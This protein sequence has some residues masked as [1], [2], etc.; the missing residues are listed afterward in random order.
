M[1]SRQYSESLSSVDGAESSWLDVLP[2]KKLFSIFRERSSGDTAEGGNVMCMIRENLFVW[3]DHYS[4]SPQILT[5]N[6]KQLASFPMRDTYQ[7]H[8]QY[9]IFDLLFN[10]YFSFLK[11]S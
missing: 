4:C 11:G 9:Y 2:S 6:L 3:S 5:L 8:K 1:V 10:A 7:V